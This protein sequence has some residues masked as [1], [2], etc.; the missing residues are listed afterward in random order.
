MILVAGGA[1]YIGSHLV[2]E[3]VKSEEV[4]VVDN[5]VTGYQ[6]FVDKRA[7]FVKGDIGDQSLLEEL[8][9]Q[10]PIKAVMHFAASSLVGESVLDPMK[11]YYNNVS[12]T[13]TLLNVMLKFNIKQIIFSS[14]AAIYGIP[15]VTRID[16]SLP[17]SPITPYGRSKWMVEQI[18]EDY[19]K[20][21]DFNYVILRY[22][23]AAGADDSGEI[24]ENHNPETHLIP[25]VL[26]HLAGLS[27]KI[28]IFGTDYNTPDGTCIRDFIHVLDIVQA[29]ILALESLLGGNCKT[30]IYNLG[31]GHG[32][33][34]K[35]VIETC[36][37]ITGLMATVELN[38]KR[39]GDPT[40]LVASSKKIENELGW[41]PERNLEEIIKSAWRWH[42]KSEV[43]F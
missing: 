17:P 41:K 9:S 27:E 42:R 18:L 30:A 15:D 38:A 16:E 22:F 37:R 24:G 20:A 33:S 8:F 2:K 3:L 11:Y 36:E 28:S 23:N 43:F 39:N 31:N 34:V 10:Y 1:G 35:E 19:S 26:Q 4:I 21:Y 12:S 6:E 25:I 40:R 5:L 13:I 7:I 29:H 32:S 14:T